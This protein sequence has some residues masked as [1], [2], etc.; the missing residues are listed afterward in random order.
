MISLFR[1]WKKQVENTQSKKHLLELFIDGFFYFPQ[2]QLRWKQWKVNSFIKP[3]LDRIHLKK[4]AY[5]AW[6][7]NY[8]VNRYN[9]FYRLA[10]CFKQWTDYLSL[11]D[12]RVSLNLR[13]RTLLYYLL[14][15]KYRFLFKFLKSGFLYWTLVTLSSHSSKNER[16][17]DGRKLEDQKQIDWKYF[18]TFSSDC[19]SSLASIHPLFQ[20]LLQRRNHSKLLEEI[21]E[22]QVGRVLLLSSSSYETAMMNNQQNRYTT[23]NSEINQDSSSKNLA[24]QPRKNVKIPHIVPVLS[25]FY[26]ECSEEASRIRNGK[27]KQSQALLMRKSNILYQQESILTDETIPLREKLSYFLMNEIEGNRNSLDNG[28][29]PFSRRNLQRADYKSLKFVGFQKDD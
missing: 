12:H 21:Q 18:V 27:V 4:V 3:A 8:E 29:T 22:S 28:L 7:K 19:S 2:L 26:R 10:S 17:R 24:L 6:K 16:S 9:Y 1:Y 23:F 11:K 25:H 14:L 5:N 13:K 20:D 15:K